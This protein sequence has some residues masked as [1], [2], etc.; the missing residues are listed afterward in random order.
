MNFIKSTKTIFS[1]SC[2]SLLLIN[3]QEKK[4]ASLAENF[5]ELSGYT[6]LS[7]NSRCQISAADNSNYFSSGTIPAGAST[8][9][10]RL[11]DTLPNA[12]SVDIYYPRGATIALPI[13]VLFQGGNVHSSFYSNYA[14]QIAS[15]GYVVYV[16]NRCTIFITQYF[17]RPSSAA[18]NEIYALAKSQNTRTSSVL[19]GRLDPEKMGYLGHSLGGV[20]AIYALNGICQFPFC[21]AGSSLLSQVKVTVVYGAGLTTQLDPSKIVLDSNGKAVP[22]AYLQGSLDSAFPSKDG[23]SSYENYKSIKYLVSFEGANHYNITDVSAPFGANPERNTSTISQDIG[24]SRI[25]QT[26]VFLLNAYLK[27]NATDLNKLTS[28]TLGITGVSVVSSL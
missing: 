28:N 11:S 1:M 4:E 15:N 5:I 24:L 7:T 12:G 22:V 18:G 10:D 14:A 16:P 8:V 25:S 20:T 6:L 27:A 2:F 26:T 19:F 21:D 9:V 3:C 23:L 13:V 17:L